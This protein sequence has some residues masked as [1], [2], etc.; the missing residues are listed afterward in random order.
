MAYLIDT[1]V[2]SEFRKGERANWGVRQFFAMADTDRLFLPVQVIGEIRAGIAKATRSGK[3][4]HAKAYDT[5]L[6]TLLADYG[7]RVIDFERDCAQL[8]GA[9]LSDQKKDPHTIDKQIAAIALI[10]DMTVVTRDQGEAFTHIPNLKVLNP[11]SDP[12]ENNDNSN[13]LA[14]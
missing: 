5:W 3:L 6:D 12:P 8:W 11:F 7:D 2:I 4:D 14:A 10:Y 13:A 9:L 1:N